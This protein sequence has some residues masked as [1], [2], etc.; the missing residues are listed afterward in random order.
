MISD[1]LRLSPRRPT[2]TKA[3]LVI[4]AESL[5]TVEVVNLSEGGAG[6]LVGREFPTDAKG[7]ITLRLTHHQKTHLIQARLRVANC[8]AINEEQ[9]HLGVQFTRFL[10]STQSARHLLSGWEAPLSEVAPDAERRKQSF[11]DLTHVAMRNL[12]EIL[13]S[14][15]RRAR[16]AASRTLQTLH[17]I[18]KAIPKRRRR[19][20]E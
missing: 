7:H 12:T 17:Q 6:L 18:E 3:M 10:Q 16:S 14:P 19:D 8:R 5:R 4:D 1:D 15:D 9:F 20:S 2:L 13:A 11:L